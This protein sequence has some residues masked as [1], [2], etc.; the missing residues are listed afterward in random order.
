MF[1]FRSIVFRFFFST[2]VWLNF[3]RGT[4]EW[5]FWSRRRE[6]RAPNLNCLF[7]KCLDWAAFDDYLRTFSSDGVNFGPYPVFGKYISAS[8][9]RFQC[10]LISKSSIRTNRVEVMSVG[11]FLCVLSNLECWKNIVWISC[12]V[13][14]YLWI[15]FISRTAIFILV[16][17]QLVK[18][19]FIVNKLCNWH[20]K[21]AFWKLCK[22]NRNH[23]QYYH[24][25]SKYLII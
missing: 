6:S 11:T 24:I 17:N 25:T 8:L 5:V 12:Y 20:R 15:P 23:F 19:K 10:F 16:V 7:S 13:M 18:N 22:Y 9:Y 2:A 21:W 14:H 1:Y 4:L 3:E